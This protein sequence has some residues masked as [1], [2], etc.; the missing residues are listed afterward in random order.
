MNKI[1]RVTLERHEP[2]KQFTRYVTAENISQAWDNARIKG[3]EFN[4]RIR[5]NLC[6]VYSVVDTGETPE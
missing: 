1:Y 2:F 5:K 4:T 3:A 6:V